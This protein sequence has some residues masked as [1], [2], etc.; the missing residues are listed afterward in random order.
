MEELSA[1]QDKLNAEEVNLEKLVQCKIHDV[2]T[3][4]ESLN[5][6]KSEIHRSR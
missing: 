2:N 4:E 3:K 1:Q 5:E 6:I